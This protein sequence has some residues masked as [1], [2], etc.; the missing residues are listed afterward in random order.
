MWDVAVVGAG[1]AGAAA[2]LAALAERPRARVL[3]LD[4]AAF[5]RDKA[6][7]DGVAPHV[8]D[9]LDGLG[10]ANVVSDRVPVRI[11]DLSQC[12]WTVH[13][14]MRRPAWVVPRRVLDA[15]LVEAAV[16]CGLSSSS[17][18]YATCSRLPTGWYSTGRYKRGS[19]W[20]LMV[21]TR[22][23]DGQPG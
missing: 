3:L 18:G 7:G 6:C 14:Q 16:A 13:R 8:L 20:R 10:A 11:L 1:P 23:C 21:P 9:V 19:W 5:P 22:C 2:A 12:P 15:R 17:I 4:R